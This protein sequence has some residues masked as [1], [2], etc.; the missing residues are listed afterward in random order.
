MNIVVLDG[1]TLNPGDLSWEELSQLGNLKVY[2][3]TA[4][5][6]IVNRA[7]DAEIILTNKTILNKETLSALPK[8]QYIG[9]LSTGANVVDLAYT[10][11][12]GIPVC[13]VPAYSTASVAQMT[14]ALL[15]ELTSR[16]GEHNQ[17]VINGEWTKSVDFCYWK[18]PLAELEGKTIGLIGLG[19]IGKQVARIAH[20]F[21]MKVMAFRKNQ[22]AIE[23]ITYCDPD[24][25]FTSSDFISLHCPLTDE[26]QQIINAS[27][28]KKMKSSA[29]IINTGRGPLIDEQALA[30]ALNE[31]R[32]AGAGLDVL[33]QEPPKNGSPL[34][35]AKNCYITP[36]IAWASKAA[37][38]RLYTIVVKNVQA[39]LKGN[40]VNV[41]NL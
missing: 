11:E 18:V 40:P 4:P 21:D 41:V 10:K 27:S 33:S 38:E 37:R 29:I 22:E 2:D 15:L 31:G 26:T 23:G 1:Y 24:T 17:S 6:E 3:R 32:I 7:K 13:N 19:H 35:G 5:D 36:H 34:I 30:D 9:L 20:A 39:Y 28:L 25:L 12:I 8:A 14:F 16:V